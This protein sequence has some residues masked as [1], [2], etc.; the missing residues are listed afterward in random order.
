MSKF[1]PKD[2]DQ[3]FDILNILE[4][5]LKHSCAAIVLACT[6]VFINFTKDN[7]FIYQQVLKR[8]KDPLITLM[9]SGEISGNYE[10]SYIILSHI[11]IIILK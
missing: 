1:S 11:Y 9:T 2:E 4:D 7:D 5:K 10:M 3:L 6:K 8:L